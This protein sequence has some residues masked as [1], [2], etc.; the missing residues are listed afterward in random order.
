[1]KYLGVRDSELWEPFCIFT[2]PFAKLRARTI[3]ISENIPT[4]ANRVASSSGFGW[5]S[6]QNPSSV[7]LKSTS[8]SKLPVL[9]SSASPSQDMRS[10][11]S[12]SVHPEFVSQLDRECQ[13]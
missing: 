10:E 12:S 7:V 8:V 13:D 1:L 5:Y 4:K 2:H 9:T 3:C 6:L 11:T